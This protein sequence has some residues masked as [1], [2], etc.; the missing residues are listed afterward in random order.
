MPNKRLL[1][2]SFLSIFLSSV[3][4]SNL[5]CAYYYPTLSCMLN[6]IWEYVCE[7]RME[8]FRRLK[9]YIRH[10]DLSNIVKLAQKQRLEPV[11]NA[12]DKYKTILLLTA[13]NNFIGFPNDI[14]PPP[15]I[16]FG[17]SA[18][19]HFMIFL[20]LIIKVYKMLFVNVSIDPIGDLLV[21]YICSSI[22]LY[23]IYSKLISH[24]INRVQCKIVEILLSHG[25]DVNQADRW[26]RTPLY[27]A[28]EETSNSELVRLLLNYHA[29]LDRRNK[30]T[31]Y[32]PALLAHYLKSHETINALIQCRKIPLDID[33]ADI[34]TYTCDQLQNTFLKRLDNNN[35]EE[36]RSILNNKSIEGLTLLAHKIQVRDTNS[37]KV[38]I[39]YAK[40][41]KNII[42]PLASNGIAYTIYIDNLKAKH[43]ILTILS[44]YMKCHMKIIIVDILSFIDG[45]DLAKDVSQ[46]IYEYAYGIPVEFQNY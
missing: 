20:I 4:Y 12:I 15:S 39:E 41:N 29:E 24:R 9:R 46:H 35:H 42:D 25:A 34:A 3:L 43:A 5:E 45:V 14:N 33:I 37:L 32:S 2:N 8:D 18:A 21:T 23:N 17:I 11:I 38:L 31:T 22:L 13:I 7:P 19:T 16:F 6:R 40:L 28:I 1:I 30:N 26:D 27:I 36:K 44:D 10:S